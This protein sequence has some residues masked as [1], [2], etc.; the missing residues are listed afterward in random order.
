MAA[1]NRLEWSRER[2]PMHPLGCGL[3][4][5]QDQLQCCKA[6]EK[7]TKIKLQKTRV[8]HRDISLDDHVNLLVDKFLQ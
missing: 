4:R 5:G 2:G 6:V 7:V 1:Q 8:N 3:N